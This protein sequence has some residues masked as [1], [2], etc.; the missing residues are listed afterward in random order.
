MCTCL[1]A[2]SPCQSMLLVLWTLKDASV[3]SAVAE[4]WSVSVGEGQ[5]WY[6]CLGRGGV[7]AGGVS[8]CLKSPACLSSIMTEDTWHLGGG[9]HQT[10]QKGLGPVTALSVSLCTA[11][12]VNCG[13]FGGFWFLWLVVFGCVWVYLYT[14]A[15]IHIHTLTSTRH[16]R[17]HVMPHT[18]YW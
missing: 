9:G 17:I 7:M 6:L 4:S 14:P 13:D 1:S 16:T 18:D 15:F 5:R 8:S 12:L 3:G 11:S 2:S 10:R